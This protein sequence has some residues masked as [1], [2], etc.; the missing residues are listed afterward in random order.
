MR[1]CMV[2]PVAPPAQAANSL[3]P[4]LLIQELR[5]R[6]VAASFVSHPTAGAVSAGGSLNTYVPR[7]GSGLLHSSRAGAVLAGTR[8]AMGLSAALRV[9]DLAHLHSNGLIVE[10]ASLLARWRTT[11]GI[12]TLYGT[13]IWHH[14]PVVHRRFAEVVTGAAH[15]IFYSRA[16]LTHARSLGLAVDPSTVIHAPVAGLFRTVSDEE[17]L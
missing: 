11:P 17:R 14:D 3:L 7:R 8:I 12:I 16:L 1:I 9:A 5:E 4:E 13:D 6:G 10:V 2:S 15:R